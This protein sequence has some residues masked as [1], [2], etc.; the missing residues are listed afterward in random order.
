MRLTNIAHMALPQGRVHSFHLTSCEST[1]RALP[2]S[3]DQGRHVGEGD[4]PG[5]WMA[6]ACRIAEATSLED[7]A[8]AWL[9]VIA[10]HGTLQTAF[11]LDDSYVS[12]REIS[13]ERGDWQEHPVP[14]GVLTRDVVRH[15]LDENCRPFAAPSHRLCV[16]EPLATA[17]DRRLALVIAS[18]HSHV[19][20]WSLLVMLRDLTI[21][22]DPT[23]DFDQDAAP[24][25][26]HTAALEHLPPAPAEVTE[27]WHELLRTG[28]NMMPV[29]PMPLGDVS[30]A[31]REVVEVRDVLDSAGVE[32]FARRAETA[33]VRIIALALGI[34][35]A[36]TVA[37]TGSPLRVVFPVHSR[38]NPRWHDSVGWFITNAIL[39]CTD[40]DAAT[41]AVKEAITLGSYPLAPILEPYGGM[42]ATPGMFA[43]SW[44]D[45]RRLPV[46][47][48]P[49]FEVQYV[50][51]V[52]PTD[53]VM[54]WFIVNDTGLHL[55]CRYPDTPEAR[56]N[57]GAWIDR[58]QA[59]VQ[60]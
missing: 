6:L 10:R 34:I 8:T 55:R 44:L 21:A 49:D 50:S 56:E 37:M 1:R 4:R 45:T 5:S 29:F 47:V 30:S 33:G 52:V 15:V 23:Q 51:A 59:A 28:S 46:Q 13:V 39:E 27:R 35:T 18:D 58:V 42:P 41:K 40:P 2:V 26:E 14:E 20:M 3:F 43:L 24:F 48:A 7:L 12:L 38:N 9:S 31:R 22:L 60:G 36:V 53:G 17:S 57:V 54:I 32:Q 11:S 16:V 19:D 25:A